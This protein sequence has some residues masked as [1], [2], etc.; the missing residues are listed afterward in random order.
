MPTIISTVILAKPYKITILVW[1]SIVAFDYGHVDSV[2][3]SRGLASS[4]ILG[5][6]F[7]W[8]ILLRANFGLSD[9]P[10]TLSVALINKIAFSF[11]V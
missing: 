4:A 10:S 6:T 1:T 11:F 9:V 7:F 3:S 8:K 2:F 5:K